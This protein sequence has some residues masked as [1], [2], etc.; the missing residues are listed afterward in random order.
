MSPPA[1]ADSR[2]KGAEWEWPKVNPSKGS[3]AG[4]GAAAPEPTP[5]G[6]IQQK[7][8]P[9]V[10]AAVEFC[11]T[12]R[13]VGEPPVIC[14]LRPHPLALTAISDRSVRP[15]IRAGVA[16]SRVARTSVLLGV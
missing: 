16:P 8:E 5:V 3:V 12:H 10:N 14:L 7:T 4:S 15:S 1:A 6:S 2:T 9:V 13:L 11:P